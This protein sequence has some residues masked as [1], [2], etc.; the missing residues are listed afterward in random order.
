MLLSSEMVL[1]KLAKRLRQSKPIYTRKL[2]KQA[3]LN[4]ARRIEVF[5]ISYNGAYPTNTFFLFIKLI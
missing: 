5:S 3:S 2:V 1:N 4:V